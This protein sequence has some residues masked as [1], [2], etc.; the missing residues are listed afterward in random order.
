MQMV[1]DFS[2]EQATM[3]NPIFWCGLLMQL[4]SKAL[5]RELG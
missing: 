5:L 2:I 4:F 1:S 3:K